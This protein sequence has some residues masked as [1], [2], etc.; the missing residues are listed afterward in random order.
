MEET[1][2]NLQIIREIAKLI[3]QGREDEV[4]VEYQKQSVRV[5]LGIINLTNNI[6]RIIE[7]NE[8]LNIEVREKERNLHRIIKVE[9]VL[10]TV[11][12]EENQRIRLEHQNT[13]SQNNNQ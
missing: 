9:Q 12:I 7:D 1:K 11:L 6:R 2:R 4:K 8:R 3:E 10:I 13:R 5:K